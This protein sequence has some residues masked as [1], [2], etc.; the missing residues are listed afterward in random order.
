M[1]NILQSKCSFAIFVPTR[2]LRTRS[3]YHQFGH[4]LHHEQNAP[5]ISIHSSCSELTDGQTRFG[6]ALTVV[7]YNGDLN[8]VKLLLDNGA[9]VKS[10]DGFPLQVAAAQGHEEIV[11]ELL[12]RED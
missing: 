8:L 3:E 9:D 4:L 5:A 1:E 7:A 12:E 11:K 2:M 6:T 10:T